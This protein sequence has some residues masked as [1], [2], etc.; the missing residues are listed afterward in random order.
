GFF[1]S[2]PPL[3][4]P[5]PSSPIE[6]GERAREQHQRHWPNPALGQS[7]GVRIKI[8]GWIPLVEINFPSV[9]A[10]LLLEQNMMARSPSSASPCPHRQSDRRPNARRF[11]QTSSCRERAA[12]PK[13][14]P[15]ADGKLFPEA[16]VTS[17]RLR[18][19]QATPLAD[20]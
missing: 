19:C 2:I 1:L 12:G 5:S 11:A 15:M 13:S 8:P 18:R 20:W 17:L 6:N 14:I 3:V 16:D 9:S 4:Q 7:A 10:N